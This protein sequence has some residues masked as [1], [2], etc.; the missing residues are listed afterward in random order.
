M[1]L[2]YLSK[3]WKTRLAALS[4]LLKSPEKAKALPMIQAPDSVA[5]ATLEKFWYDMEFS[6]VG[7]YALLT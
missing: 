7:L 5:S 1:T 4:A 3:S 2:S 6:G